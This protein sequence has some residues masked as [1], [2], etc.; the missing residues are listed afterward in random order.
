[1]SVNVSFKPD[2]G[3]SFNQWDYVLTNFGISPDNVWM[4]NVEHSTHRYNGK[5]KNL[6]LKADDIVLGIP[7]IV[8]QPVNGRYIQGITSLIDFVHPTDALYVF[9]G[10]RNNMDIEGDIGNRTIDEIVYIPT[11]T[12]DEMYSW[13]AA[14]IVFY[15]R[16][17]K[18]G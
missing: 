6:H 3:E 11:Q 2:C 16:M 8:V 5:F 18:N 13:I 17:T 1:M 12:H 7:L 14:A 9:G 10:D 15:D 4:R